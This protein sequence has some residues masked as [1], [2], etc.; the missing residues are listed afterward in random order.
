M[1]SSRA[2]A[3]RA[4]VV[5]EFARARRADQQIVNLEL[6]PPRWRFLRTLCRWNS[7]RS[8]TIDLPALQ[9][10][11]RNALRQAAV[12]L[13]HRS[14][15]YARAVGLGPDGSPRAANH[16]STVAISAVS[17]R[18][19]EITTVARGIVVVHPGSSA[20]ARRA[21]LSLFAETL[22][23]ARAEREIAVIVV[24][25][26]A[27]KPLASSLLAAMSSKVDGVSWAGRLTLVELAALLNLA[28]LFIGNDSGPLKLAEAVGAPTLSFFPRALARQ[29]SRGRAV[30]VT[31]RFT[32]TTPPI[33]PC[34][35][36]CPC[37]AAE[38]PNSNFP[39]RSPF[40]DAAFGQ[41]TGSTPRGRRETWSDRSAC[42]AD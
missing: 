4:E 16:H 39:R 29:A 26:A 19:E 14:S 27:E 32:S 23:R 24:G 25:T 3:W 2:L 13:P 5:R 42:Q 21:P 31:A 6:Y 35:P 38:P 7:G 37:W 12:T 9:A 18:L 8:R 11:E 17:S 22:E 15:Y 36:P 20:N 34:S 33:R 30:R 28:D 40:R 41:S 10:D 1:R